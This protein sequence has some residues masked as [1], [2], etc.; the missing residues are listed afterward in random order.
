M[1]G[2]SANKFGIGG[3]SYGPLQVLIVGVQIRSEIDLIQLKIKLANIGLMPV[4]VILFG[5]GFFIRKRK[6]TAAV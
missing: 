1:L 2:H 6:K 3:T 5:I 4:L